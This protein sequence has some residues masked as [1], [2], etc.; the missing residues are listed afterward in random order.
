MSSGFPGGTGGKEPSCQCRRRKRRWFPPWV[1]KIPWRRAHQLTPGELLPGEYHGQRNLV[2]NLGLQKVG[3]DWN[4]LAR[5][6][7]WALPVSSFSIINVIFGYLTK[8]LVFSLISQYNQNS[9]WE[10][11]HHYWDFSRFLRENTS[12]SLQSSWIWDQSEAPTP[13]NLERQVL[14]IQTKETHCDF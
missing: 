5:L 1:G 14:H 3:H 6:H 10:T 4:D 13:A 11:K 7:K 2:G 8:Y 9:G 12:K